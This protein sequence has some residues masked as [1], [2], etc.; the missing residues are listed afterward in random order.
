M[1][2]RQSSGRSPKAHAERLQT[3]TGTRGVGVG[4]LSPGILDVLP[5]LKTCFVTPRAFRISF[6][7]WK[8]KAHRPEDQRIETPL[9]C[10]SQRP[11][12][13]SKCYVDSRYCPPLRKS[14]V[15]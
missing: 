12:R 15:T 8:G 5:S 9:F 6:I 7:W 4:C 11:H 13:D 14:A 1:T 2:A 3:V 10:R